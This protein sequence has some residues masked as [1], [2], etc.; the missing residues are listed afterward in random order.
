MNATKYNPDDHGKCFN[1]NADTDFAFITE[2]EKSEARQ[3]LE[4][5]ADEAREDLA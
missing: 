4:L 3:R 2:D 5:L 1:Q